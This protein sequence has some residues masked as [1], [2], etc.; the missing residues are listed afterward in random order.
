M[1]RQGRPRVLTAG[2]RPNGL[3][4]D[5]RRDCAQQGTPA[6]TH[7]VH[8]RSAIHTIK[9]DTLKDLVFLI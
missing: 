8:S 7:D 9:E 2:G 3:F 5:E 1:H 6:D 4:L